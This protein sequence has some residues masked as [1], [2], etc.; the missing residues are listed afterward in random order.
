MCSLLRSLVTSGCF[1]MLTEK[2]DVFPSSP[3]GLTALFMFLLVCPEQKKEQEKSCSSVVEHLH[4]FI[5]CFLYSRD[6]LA[7][8]ETSAIAAPIYVN[9][10]QSA[11]SLK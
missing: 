9:L 10:F 7:R 1:I 11:C 5:L 6:F 8:I 4:I 2:S 3:E